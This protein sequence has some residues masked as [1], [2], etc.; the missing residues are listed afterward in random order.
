VIG[1]LVRC[2]PAHLI[3]ALG[4]VLLAFA[5]LALAWGAGS[6]SYAA[7]VP[8]MLLGGTGAVLTIPL[9]G[10]ALA[11]APPAKAGVASGIF[12][13]ARETGGCIG[14][15]LTS[16][17]VSLGGHMARGVHSAAATVLAAGYSHAMVVAGILTLTTAVLTRKMLRPKATVTVPAP[18]QVAEPTAVL[19][20][21]DSSTE[22]E[23]AS[24]NAPT[25]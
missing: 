16:A 1:I 8:G 6:G 9:N 20:P 10:I 24:T 2:V 13:T 22:W 12:N 4:L 17:V 5:F 11:A 25:I 21:S 3:V 15:A 18:R 19:S 7:L 14:V 23:M